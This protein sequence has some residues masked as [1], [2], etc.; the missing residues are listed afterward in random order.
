MEI[1]ARRIA[2]N[3]RLAQAL[4]ALVLAVWFDSLATI[5]WSY[6]YCTRPS[7][8][9]AYP[10]AGF[11]FPYAT[12]SHASSLEFLFIPQ[13]LALN[14]LLISAAAYPLVRHLN[15]AVVA[16][17]ALRWFKLVSLVVLGVSI[18][19]IRGLSLTL[20]HPVLSIGDGSYLAYGDLRPVGITSPDVVHSK[21][22]CKASG[23]WFPDGWSSK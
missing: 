9:P 15:R 16:K 14:L 13:V 11:P 4:A 12:A 23:F 22:A 21:R 5:E 3:Q 8:G 2:K 7:D 1:T 19:V 20:A 6:P 17:P 18:F 10:A